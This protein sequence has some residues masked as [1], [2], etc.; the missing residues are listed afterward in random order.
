MLVVLVAG[1]QNQ[2][3]PRGCYLSTCVALRTSAYGVVSVR[4]W[5]GEVGMREGGLLVKRPA[6]LIRKFE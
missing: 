2:L 5:E 3:C 6:K 1:V 4:G